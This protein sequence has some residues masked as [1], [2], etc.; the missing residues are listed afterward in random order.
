MDNGFVLIFSDIL[1]NESII[2]RLLKSR[3]DIVIVADA[4]YPV[5][6]HEVDKE[7]DLIIGKQEGGYHRELSSIIE[8]E[9]SFIGKKIKKEIATHEFIGIAKFS[10]YGAKNLIDVYDDCLK[11]HKGKFHESESFDKASIVDMLQEMID[12]GFKIHYVETN[13]GWME[14]HNKKDYEM[15]KRII[16]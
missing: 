5:H 10:K 13:K 7:L 1:F 15:A 16:Y 9:V 8:K 6:R 12:R 4:S 11:S 3:E 14:I 2:T